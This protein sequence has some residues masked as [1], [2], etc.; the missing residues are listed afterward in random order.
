MPRPFAVIGFTVFF[1][2]A[3]LY[4][5]DTRTVSI[6]LFAFV[7]ALSA[8]LIFSRLRSHKVFPCAF[9]SEIFRIYP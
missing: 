2:I 3:L 6:A 1:T 7:A 5:S 9:I 4:N 8:S